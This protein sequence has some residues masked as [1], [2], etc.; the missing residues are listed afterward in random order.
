[1]IDITVEVPRIAMEWLRTPFAFNCCCKGKGVDCAR[2]ITAVFKEAGLIPEGYHPPPEHG[3][4]IYGKDVNERFFAE[5]ILQYAYEIPFNERQA[6]DV[7]SFYW[8]GIESHLAILKTAKIV[9]HA[10]RDKAVLM[11]HLS[12]FM[13]KF[14]AVYR[15]KT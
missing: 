1:M 3:N 14:C 2:F 8:K 7:V 4:W 11:H 9:I 13:D 15:V 12:A 10:V 6:G 5:E